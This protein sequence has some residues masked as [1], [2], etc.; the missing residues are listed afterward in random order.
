M[1][2][3]N[4]KPNT[5]GTVVEGGLSRPRYLTP[6]DRNEN[7]SISSAIVLDN[8]NK[9]YS[10]ALTFQLTKAYE[11]GLY[12]SIAYTFTKAEE[13]T[14]NPGSQAASVWNGNPNVGTSN[15][16]EL[17]SSQYA[18]PHRIIGNVSYRYEYA[19]HFATTLSLF[20]EGSRSGNFSYVVNGDM[21]GDGNGSTD[22]MYIPRDAS[23]MNFEQ[24]SAT[25]GGNPVTFT[26]ADQEAAF[27]AFIENSEY[28]SK[29]RGEFAE[30]NSATVP[31]YNRWDLRFLQDFYIETGKN[32][33]RHTLQFSID[34]LNVANFLN[35]DWGIQKITKT[36][37]PLQFRSIDGNNAPLYR[38]QQIGGQLVTDPYQDL[39]SPASTWSLQMGLRYIF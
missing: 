10:T 19:K 14:A 24:Y 20:Y 9:G 15:A 1:F 18:V 39:I 12:G 34:I 29:H 21:N 16:I 22:L 6:A 8:T 38:Y 36:N 7:S 3:A 13:V 5:N 17:A 31:W 26:V 11:K 25:I 33:T 23:E 27:N 32:N 28:L 30:R 37:N 35:K 2:N 4:F